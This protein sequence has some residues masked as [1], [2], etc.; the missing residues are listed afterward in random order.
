MFL[1]ISDAQI[2]ER[3]DENTAREISQQCVPKHLLMETKTP[4]S[5]DIFLSV[6]YLAFTQSL[7][8]LISHYHGY[9]TDS[10]VESGTLSRVVSGVTIYS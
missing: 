1:G 10:P 3:G 8:F 2:A 5:N 4:L 6:L 9:H 7:A